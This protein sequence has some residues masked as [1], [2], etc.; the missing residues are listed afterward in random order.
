MR[1]WPLERMDTADVG[2]D[3]R[4]EEGGASIATVCNLNTVKKDVGYANDMKFKHDNFLSF[5]QQRPNDKKG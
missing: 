2:T 5:G 1:P 4:T 3:L